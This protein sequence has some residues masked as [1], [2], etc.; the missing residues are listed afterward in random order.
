MKIQV[1]PLRLVVCLFLLFS[2]FLISTPPAA[3]ASATGIVISQVY[4]G[5]GNA[6]STFKNDFIEIFNAD[7]APV[8]LTGWSVQYASAAG[9]TWQVTALSG[10]IAPG[11]YFLIQESQGAGGTTN[12]P[13]PNATGTIA[14]AAT[15]GKVALVSS[16]TALSGS[17][18]VGGAIVDFVGYGTGASGASCFE[19]TAA[20]PTLTN[21]TADLRKNNGLQDT[22]NNSADFATGA[23][24]PRNTPVGTTNP[25]GAGAATP[26]SVIQGGATLLTVLVNPGSS[27]T[28]TGITVSADLSSIGGTAAQQ[29]FDDG[30]NGDA[31][32]GD[33]T[34]SFSTTVAAA[35]T[36][37]TKTLPV[38]DFRCPG[39][40]RLRHHHSHSNGNAAE[41]FDS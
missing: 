22:D 41:S 33:N 19:G 39:S 8:D 30:T 12:L 4:G 37:G 13:T 26:S 2:A 36:P 32:A 11:Q 14:M 15:A 29:F 25:S 17:C 38:F 34:F 16:T 31:T 28:S 35:T 21:T 10:S 9:T 6:G 24:N 7:G 27:P 3:H 40:Y 20:A 1:R 5:G 18:P 23:P